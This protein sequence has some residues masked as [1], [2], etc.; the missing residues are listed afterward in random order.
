MNTTGYIINGTL[1]IGK[2][3]AIIE[4]YSYERSKKVK[5]ADLQK[6]LARGWIVVEYI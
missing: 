3:H 5:L 2:T 4:S 6:W 1:I